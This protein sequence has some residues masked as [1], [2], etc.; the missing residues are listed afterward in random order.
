MT[1]FQV[2]QQQ[3]R[4]VQAYTL[5]PKA[6]SRIHLLGLI[7]PT[8]REWTDGVLTKIARLIVSDAGREDN[9]NL[10]EFE[11]IIFDTF[12]QKLYLGSSVTETSI[13]NGLKH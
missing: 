8:T 7:D 2:L 4:K 10:N 12:I 3:K 9:L 13:L 6:I 11:V 5:N 1:I